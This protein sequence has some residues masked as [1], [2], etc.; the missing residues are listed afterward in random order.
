M[1]RVELAQGN[2]KLMR[3]DMPALLLELTRLKHS[4]LAKEAWY[5]DIPFMRMI[6]GS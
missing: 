2:Q 5:D 6:I 4:M 3:V 1:S